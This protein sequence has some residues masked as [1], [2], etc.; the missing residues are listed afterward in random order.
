MLRLKDIIVGCP[1]S[2]TSMMARV[3][4]LSGVGVGDTIPGD[5]VNPEGFFEDWKCNLLHMQLLA[6]A[7]AND[8][9]RTCWYCDETYEGNKGIEEA[10][11]KFLEGYTASIVKCPMF[12]QA[13]FVWERLL[14]KNIRMVL[15]RRNSH[16]VFVS[17]LRFW[18]KY[19]A[20]GN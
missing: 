6:P 5:E 1:R 18:G 10:C 20:P 16:D 9:F 3:L 17:L 15:V 2:G 8:G 14:P 7:Y 4:C 11:K 13:W 19:A 12:V